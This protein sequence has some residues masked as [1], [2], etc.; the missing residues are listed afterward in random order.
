[1]M[2]I[3]RADGLLI[4]DRAYQARKRARASTGPAAMAI[5]DT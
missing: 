1:M 5:R 4:L 3:T 2:E